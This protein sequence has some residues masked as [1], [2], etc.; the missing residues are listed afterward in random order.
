M[1]QVMATPLLCIR[2][3]LL[4]SG[5]SLCLRAITAMLTTMRKRKSTTFGHREAQFSLS[6]ILLMKNKAGP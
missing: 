1:E 4:V 6:L 3:T 5:V 2:P